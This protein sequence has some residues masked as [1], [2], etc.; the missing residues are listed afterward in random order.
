MSHEK[1]S[2][3]SLTETQHQ[4]LNHIQAAAAAG[5]T[6]KAY[7]AAHGL[8]VAA[9]YSHK[10]TLKRRGHL[11]GET[12]TFA[13]V[14]LTPAAGTAPLRIHLTNGVMVEAPAD[15]APQQVAALC[16]DLGRLP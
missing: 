10:A 6:L 4:Y 7:A 5:Q 11:G 8:S 16:H 13:R 15:M 9:L 12:A 2:S 3:R 1:D 14:A